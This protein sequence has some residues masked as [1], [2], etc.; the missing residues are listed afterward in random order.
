MSIPRFDDKFSQAVAD[1]QAAADL[2]RYLRDSAGDM[3]SSVILARIPDVLA[4]AKASSVQA[5][6][7]CQKNPV[8]AAEAL[9]GYPGAAQSVDALTA[10]SLAVGAAAGDWNNALGGWLATLSVANLISLRAVD[11]GYGPAGRVVW[12]DGFAE[13]LVTPLRKSAGLAAL[14]A[15]FEAAGAT[16]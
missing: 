3:Q 15:A 9:K 14:I 10:S 2:L 11:M 1:M 13:A 16:A 8:A 7:E 4:A 5:L 12:A 6:L